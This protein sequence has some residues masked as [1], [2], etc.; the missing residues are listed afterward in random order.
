MKTVNRQQIPAEK[1][2]GFARWVIEL[3][4]GF[5]YEIVRKNNDWSVERIEWVD[6]E[7]T[8]DGEWVGVPVR[9]ASV[10]G[11]LPDLYE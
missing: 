10:R 9:M 4:D 5:E 1:G 2:A 7:A 3:A 8:G 6:D 11:M